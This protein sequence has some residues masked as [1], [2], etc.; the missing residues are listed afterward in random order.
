MTDHEFVL[1]GDALWLDFAN[2]AASPSVGGD[3]IADP[4]AYHRW[5]KAVKLSSDVEGTSFDDVLRF[6]GRLVALASALSAGRQPPASTIEAINGVLA[7]FE[8]H[9]QLTRVNGAWRTRFRSARP[10][11]AL[12]AIA[13]SAAT[14]L[15]EPTGTV[16][17]CAGADCTLFFADHSPQQNRRWCS[18][19]RCGEKLR[20][21]R[22]RGNRMTPV[23]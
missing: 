1:L 17:Q 9:H 22:R 6:R 4:A 23:V 14:T 19:A 18:F 16:R 20:V 5:T 3:Q 21:E 12:A 8:G 11:S 7:Q 13:A 10:P 2:T 15:S